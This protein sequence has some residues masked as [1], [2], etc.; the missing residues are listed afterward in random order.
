MSHKQSYFLDSFSEAKGRKFKVTG[1]VAIMI[2]GVLSSL[3]TLDNHTASASSS[4]IGFVLQSRPPV[5]PADGGTYS[6]IV[7]QLENLTS[8]TPYIPATSVTVQLTSSSPQTGTVPDTV[9]LLAGQLFQVVNFSTTT[10]PGQAVISAIASG[11]AIGSMTITT[12]T[13][14]GEPVALD[15]FLSPNVIPPDA[16]LSS[17]VIVEAVDAFNNPVEL[18]SSLTVSLSSSNSQVGSVPSTLTIPAGQSFAATTF[19]PT[20]IAGQTTITAQAGNYTTGSAVM[21]TSGPVARKLVLSGPTII[22]ASAGQTGLL[23][24]QLQDQGV[25]GSVP[26]LAPVAVSVVL[27]DNNTEVASLSSNTV[28]IPAGSSYT[29]VELTSE[30]QPGTANITASAQGYE[31]GS[32]LVQGILPWNNANTLMEYFVPGTLLPDNATYN[33]ALV[34][35]LGYYNETT[36]SLIPSIADSPVTVYA[37]SSDNST[38]QVETGYQGNPTISGLIPA[39]ESEVAISISSTFLPGT[40][41][42]TSQSPGLASTTFGLLSFGPS[43][44]TLSIQFAPPT[45]ISGGSY[46]AITVGLIDNSTGEPAR[47]PVDTIVQLASTVSSVGEVQSSVT[48]PAG[49]TYAR[50]TFTTSQLNGTTLI[51]ASASNFTSANGT[52]SLVQPAAA[53]LALYTV[54]NPVLGNGQGYESMVVQLQNLAGLPEKTDVNVPVQLAIGNS[55]VGSV[56]PLVIIPSGQTFAQIEVQAS[57]LAGSTNITATSNGF[58]FSQANFTTFLLPMQVSSYVGQPHLLPGGQTNITA[59]VISQ[60]NPVSGAEVNWTT[61]EGSFLNMENITDSNGSATALYSAGSLPGAILVSAAVS[62]PGYTPVV[63]QASLRIINATLPTPKQTNILESKVGFIPIWTLIV[64]AIAVP[65]GA[66]LFIRRRSSGGYS[67]DE[68]E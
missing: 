57:V 53:K 47:A 41:E 12:E 49:Q 60:D 44:N 37:R 32:D 7:I 61:A 65:A 43:A 25:N 2:L 36:G 1:L 52:L 31:K 26:A 30:G 4:N 29:T 46:S 45:L 63:E 13:V 39:S 18:G 42:I 5:L 51:T 9:T 21:T 19:Q 20:Y 14:G 35:Q 54:P 68:E 50:A 15:V 34:V 33:G 48:I 23:S 10:L 6:S 24:I 55:T 22:P 17:E 66:F 3:S 27:T 38:M 8:H 11:Y 64:I 40:A 62:K 58:Q 56:P 59:I 16:T 67:V 28:T